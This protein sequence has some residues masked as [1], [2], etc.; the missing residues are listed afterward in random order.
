MRGYAARELLIVES[1]GT[2]LTYHGLT[3]T[4]EGFVR[5]WGVSS[6]QLI[7]IYGLSSHTSQHSSNVPFPASVFVLDFVA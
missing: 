6:I 2:I 1:V 7:G 4:W 3:R 5:I